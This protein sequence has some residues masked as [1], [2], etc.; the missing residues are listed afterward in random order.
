M[1]LAVHPESWE[2]HLPE[3]IPTHEVEKNERYHYLCRAVTFDWRQH[4]PEGYN[5]RR[6]DRALLDDSAICF[7]D[8]LRASL[9]VTE[10]WW[11]MDHFLAKGVGF[12]VLEGREAVSWCMSD[13]AAGDRMDVGVVTHPSRRRQGLGAVV[14]AATVEHCLSHGF[15][16]VGWHCNADN[17]AS[18]RTAEKVGFERQRGYAYYYYMYDPVDHLAE[19]GWYHYKRGQYARTVSYYEQVFALRAENPD[20]Y[21]HLMASAWALLGDGK[22]ALRYLQAAADHGW[23]DLQWTSQQGEFAFLHGDPQWKELLERQSTPEAE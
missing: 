13:C 1:S 20:Y 5:V 2:A 10:T 6:L 18:W 15:G 19:S 8:P 3:L 21:Y 14:V 7:P 11:T 23:A 17:V 22:Q 4:V 16:A 12:C 9:D